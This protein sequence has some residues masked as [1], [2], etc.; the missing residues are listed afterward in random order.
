MYLSTK[1]ISRLYLST[2]YIS[3]QNVHEY[4]IKY[5]FKYIKIQ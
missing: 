3:T 4:I 1:Y 2:K 5:F